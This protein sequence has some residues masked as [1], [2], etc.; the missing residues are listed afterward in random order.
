MAS[1]RQ[2]RANRRNALKSTGPRTA[3]GK[4]ASAR[5]AL[6][7]GLTAHQVVIDGEDPAQFDALL[8][9]F[10]GEF[11][12]ESALEEFLVERLAGLAWRLRRVPLFEAALLAWIAHRQA[13]THGP[14]GILL[15]DVFLS[16]EAGPLSMVPPEPRVDRRDAHERRLTGRMLAA[17][18]SKDDFLS[19]LG[20]YEALLMK[21]LAR[22]LA[23]LR[24]L[25]AARA[26]IERR[27]KTEVGAHA[28]WNGATSKCAVNFATED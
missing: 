11:Q 19:K 24:E 27:A 20:R 7:H 15:G 6:R 23:A 17:V 12:P 28:L 2:I 3:A 18:L 10:R 1:E 21:Q 8:H 4:T 25:I 22:T 9:R 16:S 14:T 5:N 13:E 26:E